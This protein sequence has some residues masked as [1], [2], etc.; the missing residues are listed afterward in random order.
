MTV[1]QF[2]RDFKTYAGKKVPSPFG[3]G[4]DPR[5]W[6]VTG[7][8]GKLAGRPAWRGVLSL[9]ISILIFWLNKFENRFTTVGRN[10]VA[11]ALSA[12]QRLLGLV[13][14]PNAVMVRARIV[15]LICEHLA[16]DRVTLSFIVEDSGGGM[17]RRADVSVDGGAWRAVFPDDG[18]ADSPRE[19]FTLDLPLSGAGEHT[20]ALRGFDASG[21]MG[22]ARVIVRK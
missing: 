12:D 22:N 11:I 1:W 10:D 19:T 5:R 17:V 7:E 3:G 20:I 16:N 4:R 14:F 18:I 21:N 13:V 2:A 8:S 15:R 6:I 9:G